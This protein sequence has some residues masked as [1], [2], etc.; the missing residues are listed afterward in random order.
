MLKAHLNLQARTNASLSQIV[1]SSRLTCQRPGNRIQSVEAER[2]P[3]QAFQSS[4][5]NA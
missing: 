1:W 3:K 5:L 2:A 4:M